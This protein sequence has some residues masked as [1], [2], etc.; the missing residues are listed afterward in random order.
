MAVTSPAKFTF[1]KGDWRLKK[2]SSSSSLYLDSLMENPL[3]RAVPDHL[4]ESRVYMKLS[5]NHVFAAEPGILHFGGFEIGKCH[6]QVL[7]LVNI[8]ADVCNVHI[9][10]PQSK[11][12]TIRYKKAG[13]FVPGLALS[14]DVQFVADEWRYYYDCIRIHCE[15]EETLLVPLHA[16]PTMDLL[17]FP[18]HVSFSDVPLGR[19][20]LQLLRL[21]CRCPVDFQFS[22]VCSPSHKDFDISLASGMVPGGGLVEVMVTYT[23]SCY[24]TAQVTLELQVSE[25]SARPRVCVVTGTCTPLLTARKPHPQEQNSTGGRP[26]GAHRPSYAVSRKKKHLQSLQH[27]ASQVIEFQDLRFSGDL[28][29]PHAVSTV[30]NQQPGKLKTRDL[31][32]GRSDKVRTRQEKESRFQQVMLQNVAEEEANQLRWQVRLGCDPLSVNQRHIIMEDHQSAES[33]VMGAE[34]RRASV[35]SGC[36]RVLRH[37]D[38]SPRP[39]LLFDLYL[40]DLWANRSRALSRFQQAGRRVLVRGRVDGRLRSLRKLLQ[41]LRSVREG[42]GMCGGSD[43]D[44]APAST[45]QVLLYEFP[46]YPIEL[47]GSMAGDLG[48]VPPAA[49]RL[50]YELSY[51]DLKVPQHFRAMAY[52]TVRRLGGPAGYQTPHLARPLRSGAEEELMLEETPLSGDSAAA[53]ERTWSEHGEQARR[54]ALRPPE[55]LLSPPDLPPMHVF[56]PAPG[57]TAFRRVLPYSDLHLEHHLCPLPQYSA[58]PEA[59]GGPARKGLIRGLL[60]WKKFPAVSSALP[61]PDVCRPRGCDPFSAELLPLSAV[62]ALS[63][64]PSADRESAVPR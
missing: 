52:Q 50:T 17:D 27:S 36:C 49:A 1:P 11:H 2:P 46:P 16:Y 29:N 38:E 9:I 37:V 21:C 45:R 33:Q 31:R 6:R 14:V 42:S 34:Y 39:L 59:A 22:I 35:L 26:Q 4:L 32:G 25:F 10:P 20:A 15:G 44:I 48:S 47:D 51:H 19:S 13:R 54:R 61:A 63:S 28:S 23:P 58:Q 24:G 62:P 18:S 12:F 55:T 60:T 57:L 8:S 56:T 40:N 5:S 3:K 43:E 7:K 64:L 53:P 30:L 41:R